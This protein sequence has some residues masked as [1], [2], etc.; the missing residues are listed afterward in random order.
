M[1]TVS[2]L[3]CSRCGLRWVEDADAKKC[4]RCAQYHRAPK[5]VIVA[6]VEVQVGRTELFGGNEGLQDALVR[7]G[8][9]SLRLGERC[10]HGH[11][12]WRLCQKCA[13][14]A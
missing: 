11:L 6:G 1:E 8:L 7:R 10:S 3:A 9:E 2:L 5:A 13:T 14:I 12:S 4:P